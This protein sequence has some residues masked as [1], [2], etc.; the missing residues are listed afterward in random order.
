MVKKEE[1]VAGG[2]RLPHE[3]P[4]GHSPS[5]PLRN[6]SVVRIVYT[7]PNDRLRVRHFKSE[8]MGISDCKRVNGLFDLLIGRERIFVRGDLHRDQ[9]RRVSVPRRAQQ[10]ERRDPLHVLPAARRRQDGDNGAHLHLCVQKV[11][12]ASRHLCHSG[13]TQSSS[14][15]IDNLLIF[16]P[17]RSKRG[18]HLTDSCTPY[19]AFSLLEKFLPS[20]IL[21]LEQY[22]TGAPPSQGLTHGT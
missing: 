21:Q 20:S 16:L 12:L 22:P 5:K 18:R 19:A 6:A 11:A 3:L 9:T 14:C 2:A 10:H 17:P 4:H 7:L 1:S 13:T 15:F 8:V